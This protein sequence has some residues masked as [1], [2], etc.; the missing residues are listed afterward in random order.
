MGGDATYMARL[1]Y[2]Q[3]HG[4][5]HVPDMKSVAVLMTDVMLRRGKLFKAFWDAMHNNLMGNSCPSCVARGIRES[6]GGIIVDPLD[7]PGTGCLQIDQIV[8]AYGRIKSD[9]GVFYSPSI[10]YVRDLKQRNPHDDST[11]C[12][13]YWA[14]GYQWSGGCGGSVRN[15]GSQYFTDCNS[16]DSTR[17]CHRNLFFNFGFF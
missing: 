2:T 8:S 9:L 3:L 12:K 15:H 1:M 16:F 10:N 6:W 11:V 7:R 14:S 5:R 4:A 17:Y 13:I